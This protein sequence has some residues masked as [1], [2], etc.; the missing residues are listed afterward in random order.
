MQDKVLKKNRTPERREERGERR[1]GQAGGET[2]REENCSLNPESQ[3]RNQGT[4][5]ILKHAPS[6][7]RQKV[8]GR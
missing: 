7:M 6:R 3:A 4:Y 8:Y 1:V 5:Y 2:G